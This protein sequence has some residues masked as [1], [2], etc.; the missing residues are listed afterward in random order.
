MSIFTGVTLLVVSQVIAKKKSYFGP[1]NCWTIK[2]FIHVSKNIKHLCYRIETNLIWDW[3]NL[4]NFFALLLMRLVANIPVCGSSSAK[5]LP[6]ICNFCAQP[7]NLIGSTL[8]IYT[9][10]DL[11]TAGDTMQNVKLMVDFNYS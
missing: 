11:I 9:V 3:F 2:K 5:P 10:F 7:M 8:G 4:Y 1:W 6:T